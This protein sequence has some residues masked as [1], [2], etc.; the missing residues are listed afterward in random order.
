MNQEILESG[1]SP[2]D[3][4][5]SI[6]NN[7]LEELKDHRVKIQG[8][9][10]RYADDHPE[11]G[12]IIDSFISATIAKKPDD[13]V[14]FACEHFSNLRNAKALKSIYP[15]VFAGPSGVGKGTLVNLLMTR[16]PDLFGFCVSHTT[17]QPREGEINGVH[18][19]FTDI[20]GM[21]LAIGR[22]EF[23]EYARVHTNMYGTSLKAVE[24]VQSKGKICILD[25]DI[26]GVQ[27]VKTSSI[28]C[29]YVFISPPSMNELETRLRGRNTETEEKI[30][31]RLKTA[32]DEMLYGQTDNN[33]DA[34]I[35][36]NEIE[37]CYNELIS[38]LQYWYPTYDFGVEIY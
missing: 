8:D 7:A 29:K 1:S 30:V 5:D 9:N 27:K 16:H 11:L 22:G 25:I 13:V 23:V 10:Q 20:P 19:H 35:V 15:A 28:S 3:T 33:F 6:V 18:Y 34:V 31:L 2:N 32:E 17:R 21:E 4:T 38:C 37:A 14:D 24:E 26:Q 12:G 36:N